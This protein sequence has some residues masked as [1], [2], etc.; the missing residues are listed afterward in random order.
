MISKVGLRMARPTTID[1][2]TPWNFMRFS[3][4]ER[5]QAL[6]DAIPRAQWNP[7]PAMRKSDL[8]AAAAGFVL[9]AGT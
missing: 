7:L 4:E 8:H 6:P 2:L 5:L 9:Q 1:Q 3:D